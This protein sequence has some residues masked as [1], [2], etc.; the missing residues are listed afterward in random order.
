MMANSDKFSS[1]AAVHVGNESSTDKISLSG[2][3][4]QV[5]D[6]IISRQSVFFTG[7]AGK[8]VQ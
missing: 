2:G 7:A 8:Y 1:H 6:L 5:L 4:K 3:Q